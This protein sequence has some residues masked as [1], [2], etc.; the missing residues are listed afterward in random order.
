MRGHVTGQVQR[1]LIRALKG[2]GKHDSLSPSSDI[3]K[4]N[5]NCHM[6]NSII[7]TEIRFYPEI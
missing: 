2:G 1:G 3:A 5:P 6:N 4:L 7:F